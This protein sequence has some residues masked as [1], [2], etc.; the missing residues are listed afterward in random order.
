MEQQNLDVAPRCA[1]TPELE[2]KPINSLA[3]LAWNER[4]FEAVVSFHCIVQMDRVGTH[5]RFLWMVSK[6]TD[7]C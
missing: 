2:G 4:Q 7:G 3:L 1:A 6:C 5:A